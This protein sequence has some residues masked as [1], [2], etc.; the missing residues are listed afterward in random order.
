MLKKCIKAT[1]LSSSCKLYCCK[2]GLRHQRHSLQHCSFLLSQV[3]CCICQWQDFHFRLEK[4]RFTGFGLI[5]LCFDSIK[6]HTH[7]HIC[8]NFSPLEINNF[9]RKSGLSFRSV[10]ISVNLLVF[11]KLISQWYRDKTTITCNVFVC[12]SN[13]FGQFQHKVLGQWHRS[14]ISCFTNIRI[15]YTINWVCMSQIITIFMPYL[16]G[17]FGIYFLNRQ[18]PLNATSYS[19]IV[20]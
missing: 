20:K 8:S 1:L 13:G 5:D 2:S 12:A 9:F 10:P 6:K 3:L 16:L 15:A 18:H 14:T 19:S 11:K 4:A 7:T 17:L